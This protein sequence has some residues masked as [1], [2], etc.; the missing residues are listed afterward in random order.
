MA[1]K[2]FKMKGSPM[3]R[4]FGIGSPNNLNNF[5]IGPGGSPWK[6]DDDATTT[7]TDGNGEDKENKGGEEKK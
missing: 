7:T 5:G 2:P 6:Q 1:Y 4:N 3:K